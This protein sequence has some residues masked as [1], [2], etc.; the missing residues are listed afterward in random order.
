M[1]REE[2][3]VLLRQ[4]AREARRLAGDTHDQLLIDAYAKMAVDYER[5]AKGLEDS[6]R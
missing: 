4:L 2:R 6:Q 1:S 3:L 5:M